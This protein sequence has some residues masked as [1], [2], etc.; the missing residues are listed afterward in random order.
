MEF[1][2]AGGNVLPTVSVISPAN[3]ATIT[4]LG[5]VTLNANATDT[6]GTVTK[7]EFYVNGNLLLTDTSSPYSASWTPAGTGSYTLTAKAFDNQ[8]GSST[9]SP[10]NVTVT[11]GG[12]G[13]SIPGKIE[14][15]SYG[16]M[17]GIA[18]EN[19]ADT[20]GGQNV[21]YIDTGDWMDYPVTIQ[22]AGTYAVT[23]RTAGWNAAAQLQL[24]NGATVLATVSV[25]N[26]G[27][28]QN[29]ATT[30]SVNV[31]L[32]AGNLTL[33]VGVVAGGFNFN[34][35]NFVNASARLATREEESTAMALYPNP[36]KNIVNVTG[37]DEYPAKIAIISQQGSII[38]SKIINSEK[39]AKLD[40]TELKTGTYYI[41]IKTKKTSRTERIVK[42]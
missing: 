32:P 16:T 19:A 36:S 39:E 4:G 5:A 11:T 3:N 37:I 23:F 40:L 33:R 15:E 7:V 10:S 35:M 31:P 25:P 20:G 8:N 13:L 9:S 41:S 2:Q 6:D 24:K 14:A 18:T 12:T 17:S 34:W 29:W 1:V 38:F 26:S 27:G 21:G 28:G 42:D 22:T 30:I